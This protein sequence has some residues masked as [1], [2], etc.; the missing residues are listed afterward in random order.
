VLVFDQECAAEKRRARKRGK[1][2]EPEKFVVINEEA[3][4]GCGDCGDVSNCMS[5]VPVD[6][7]F[8]RK[9]QIHQASCN[10]DY[11]CIKGDCPSFV[12]V[13]SRHGLR[14]PVVPAVPAD[15]V[16]PPV[17]RAQ[18]GEGYRIFMP[19]IGGTG[20]ITV[21][22]VLAYAALLDGFEVNLLGQTGLAQKG[23]SVLASVTLFASE[24]LGSNRISA[25]K[26]DLV[27]AFD[28]VGLV[29]P[30]N[31]D[32]M[33]PERTLV[34]GDLTV[35][36]TADAIRHVNF[37]M[38]GKSSLQLEVDR[39]S[40]AADNGWI[41]AGRIS[42]KL[43]TDPAL[44]NVFMLGYA[45]QAGLVPISAE[46]IEAAFVLNGAAMDRNLQA[47]RYGRL[48]RHTPAKVNVLTDPHDEGAE[49]LRARF[50]KRLGARST[51]YARLLDRCAG[52][53]EDSKRLLARRLGELI[54]YQDVAYAARYLATV[55]QVHSKEREVS[56]DQDKLTI[57]VIRHLYKLMAYKD[58]YEVARLLLKSPAAEQITDLFG[59]DAR[60]S[61]NLHPP[62]LRDRGLRNKL[63]LGAWF[64]PFLGALIPLRR[65]RGTPF[66]LFG[67]TPVRRA[68]RELVGWY[69]EVLDGLLAGLAPRSFK[70]AVQIASAPDRIRGYENIKLRSITVV[71]DFVDGRLKEYRALRPE[72]RATATAG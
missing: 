38:P 18:V 15:A 69:L 28:P 71:K 53:S 24:T 57:A 58:E 36:P 43:F 9:T 60:Q 41:E 4:E 11:S 47:F 8:G 17:T 27:L 68:E 10:K 22:H 45:F 61:I 5:V 6:T 65:L 48:F 52:F 49:E 23:G 50:V 39:F 30:Y 13:Y 62:I 32:R 26:A 64:R 16:P 70:L 67:R 25:G 51:D 12:T 31:A 35:Q 37:L 34:V 3:C 54:E 20:V 59:P 21:S 40:R 72:D 42:E 44:T 63:E 29:A 66:D 56:P 2:P 33:S 19:G 55:E 7:E 14:K 1:S 46:A